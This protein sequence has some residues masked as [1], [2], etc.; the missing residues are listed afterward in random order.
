MNAVIYARYSSVEQREESIEGQLRE[1]SE[2]AKRKGYTIVHSYID[3]AIS[4]KRADNRPQF[5]QL[6][7]DSK[8]GN[9]EYVIC[10]K[11]DRFSRDKYESVMYKSALKKNNVSVISA[12]EPID[13]SPEGKLMESIFEGFSEYFI[14]D[15]TLKVSRGMTENILKGKYNGRALTF[16]YVID[17]DRHF[18]YDPVKAPIVTDIFKRYANDETIKSITDDLRAKGI[19]TNQNAIPSYNF[20]N[21]MLKNRRYLG[22]YKFGE[23]VNTNAIPLLVEPIIF[24]K[25]QQLLAGNKLRPASFRRSTRNICSQGKYSAVTA[26]PLCRA[27]VGQAKWE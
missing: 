11:I 19:K 6:I 25:C 5:Q 4:G 23:T 8:Q 12:T 21:N 9:F 24:E 13:D 16:G 2:F 18:Q 27:K 10:W 22:E 14:A 3:R 26:M 7:A 17:E 1:C 20:V 15:L